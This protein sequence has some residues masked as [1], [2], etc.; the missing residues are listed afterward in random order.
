ME[1]K[2]KLD[3]SRKELKTLLCVGL[4]TDMQKFPKD[5]LAADDP[6]FDLNRRLVDAT[7]DLAAAYKLNMA[8]YESEGAKGFDPMKR[9]IAH[10][11]DEAPE[12]IIILDGKKGDIGNTSKAYAK[13]AFMTLG[14]DAVTLNGYMGIDAVEPFAE[15]QDRL[16]FVLCR[17][18]NRAAA[19]VQDIGGPS[20]P[21]YLRMAGLVRS[22]NRRG[23]L[24]LVVGATFP[25]ELSAV[26]ALVGYDMPILVPGVGAQG[27]DL[28]KV[29][30]NGTGP[31]GSGVLINVSRGIMFAFEDKAYKDLGYE[32]A[33]RTAATD[34]RESIEKE[35]VALGRW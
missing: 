26:R 34:M 10:I 23:N 11:K 31:N 18:S 7:K 3:R 17:T 29:L 21:L 35:L 14:A 20:D 24:G 12:A 19:E 5:M 13:A 4:D 25:E 16:C 6:Q 27:G 1:W 9:T 22:W 28:K 15:Y 33:A 8:F 32:R 30:E 2:M